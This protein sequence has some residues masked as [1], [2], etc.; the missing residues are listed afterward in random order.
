V[1]ILSSLLPGALLAAGERDML[2]ELLSHSL[3]GAALDDEAVRGGVASFSK[4]LYGW[5]T[6]DGH[7]CSTLDTT[8]LVVRGLSALLEEESSDASRAALREW[9]PPPAELLRIAELECVWRACGCGSAHPALLCARLHGE[10]LGGLEAAAEVAEGV[11]RIE[12]FNPLLRTE[13]YRLLG[14]AHATLG[15]RAAA[16][17][18]AERA[19]AEAAKA[20]Y[21][22]LEMVS[23]ADLLR[24]SGASEVEKVRSRLRAVAGR[25]DASADEE[26]VGVV[27]EGVL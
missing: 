7:C 2:R 9:L 21:T 16:C 22:W 26:L 8:L 24:W 27:G 13:A 18:A 12:Q 3:F 23:V 1:V 10:R 25:L 15:Q 6:S 5:S 17:E 4:G 14:G 20:R 11:L 19:V